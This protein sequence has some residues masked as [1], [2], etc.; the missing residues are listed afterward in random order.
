VKDI[1]ERLRR[2]RTK[3]KKLDLLEECKET[4]ILEINN[5]KQTLENQEN[6]NYANLKARIAH[7]KNNVRKNFAN[8]IKLGQA[9]SSSSKKTTT[10]WK[11]TSSPR[12]MT[13]T[14]KMTGKMT[15]RT[16]NS[17]IATSVA[18]KLGLVSLPSVRKLTDRLQGTHL[19]LA[20]IEA[21][22][23]LPKPVMISSSAVVH[24]DCT[25]VNRAGPA[26]R[27]KMRVK[28]AN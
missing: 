21:K 18:R 2:S 25:L 4:L 26:M 11:T 28:A 9:T 6:E 24:T 16:K 14:R 15:T 17:P 5:P 22:F 1:Y 10:V 20:Q 12:K 7:P 8:K 13:P 3:K 27:M 23:Q 19:P